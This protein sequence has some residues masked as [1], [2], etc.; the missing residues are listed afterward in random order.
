MN[1]QPIFMCRVPLAT[2]SSLFFGPSPMGTDNGRDHRSKRK[3]VTAMTVP[4][5]LPACMAPIGFIVS[6]VC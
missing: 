2:R 1:A 6:P 4:S 5:C 3:S